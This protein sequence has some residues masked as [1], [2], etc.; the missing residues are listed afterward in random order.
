[1][2]RTSATNSFLVKTVS[3]VTGGRRTI[4]AGSANSF[5][6][7]PLTG[8]FIWT[9]E[10]MF[11]HVCVEIVGDGEDEFSDFHKRD[12]SAGAQVIKLPPFLFRVVRRLRSCGV[13]F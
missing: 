12:F 6:A 11:P 8:S 4:L 2:C 7:L 10:P 3:I 5:C 9:P 1:M 13:I